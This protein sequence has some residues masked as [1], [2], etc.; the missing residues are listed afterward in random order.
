MYDT[1][2]M[3]HGFVDEGRAEGG[4]V[5]ARVEQLDLT[6]RRV[7]GANIETLKH[8]LIRKGWQTLNPQMQQ[9]PAELV[10]IESTRPD[11]SIDQSSPPLQ[12]PAPG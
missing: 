9:L 2:S 7:G 5:A 3:A 6:R 1:E 10:S 8:Q 12:L 4:Q 11:R